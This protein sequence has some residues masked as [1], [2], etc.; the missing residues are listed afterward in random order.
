MLIWK[1]LSKPL[2]IIG[3]IFG[4]KV[5]IMSSH[6]C[7]AANCKVTCK[8][9]FLMCFKHWKMVPKKLQNQVYTTYRP[10]Q[11]D[12]KN[13]SIEWHIAASKAIEAVARLEGL[14]DLAERWKKDAEFWEERIK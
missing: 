2:K 7:H 12:D 14:L 4:S 11:C 3:L 8:P 5:N 10:G 1:N 6:H 9:E 13:P